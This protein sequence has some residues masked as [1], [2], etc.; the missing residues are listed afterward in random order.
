MGYFETRLHYYSYDIQG[1]P[2]SVSKENDVVHSYVWDYN[3]T[4]PVADAINTS[5]SFIAFTS[6][7]SDG[8]GNWTGINKTNIKNDVSGIT[9]KKY[10]NL[11]GSSPTK[12]GLTSTSIYVISYWSRSGTCTVSGTAQPGWPKNS[13]SVTI[14]GVTWNYWEHQ[15]SGVSS[16]SVSG[17]VSID[18]LRLYPASS[19]M[20][21][22]TYEPLGGVSSQCD[23]NNNISY[24]EYDSYG[25]LKL[26]KDYKGNILKT[27]N[28]SYQTTTP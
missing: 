19:Q 28:Y 26:I 18:E 11:T 14:N 6:F 22:Y 17:S 20:T 7:E 1:N 23:V 21:S 3:K 15:V 27:T 10:Y 12:T 24:Y 13:R 8:M 4:Y 9:G 25:R 2:T 5:P 16:I